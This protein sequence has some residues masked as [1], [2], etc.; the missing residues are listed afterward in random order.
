M[1]TPTKSQIE[2]AKETLAQAGYLVAGGA[3]WHTIDVKQRAGE[4]GVDLTDEQA[5]EVAQRIC[6]NHDANQG[7]NW[8]T[9]DA[10]LEVC[11]HKLNF[12]HEEQEEQE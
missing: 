7:I 3:L 8:D 11:G 4:L 5:T 1:N 10:A 12:S 9:I 2:N 6:D